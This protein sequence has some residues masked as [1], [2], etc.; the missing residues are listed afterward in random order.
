MK[1]DNIFLKDLIQEGKAIEKEQES[2][3]ARKKAL[4]QQKKEYISAYFKKNGIEDYRTL[5]ISHNT[6]I[7]YADFFIRQNEEGKI[8]WIARGKRTTIKDGEVT[9]GHAQEEF[10]QG[11]WEALP[12][13][14]KNLTIEQAKENSKPTFPMSPAIFRGVD[15]SAPA[16]ILHENDDGFKLVWRKAGTAYINRMDGS[17]SSNSGLQILYSK[18]SAD[19]L[20]GSEQE[21]LAWEKI[22]EACKVATGKEIRYVNTYFKLTEGGRLSVGLLEKEEKNI[23]LIFGQGVTQ[24]IIEKLKLQ[25][26][27]KTKTKKTLKNGEDNSDKEVEND[28]LKH[29]N[30]RP[31]KLKL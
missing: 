9:Y 1:Y 13:G 18:K 27:N 6:F 23:D 16:Y 24:E 17:A 15:F 30:V 22:R 25:Q 10:W 7:S 28:P 19:S 26:A 29:P 20:K 21:K 2:L 11:Q 3:D 14:I 5:P 31:G 8:F 4:I 12:E